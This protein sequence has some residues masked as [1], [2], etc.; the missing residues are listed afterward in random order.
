MVGYLTGIEVR[1]HWRSVL[2]LALLVALVVG[3]VLASVAGAR[4]SR[5]S[6]DRYLAQVNGPDIMAT[7]DAGAPEEI[8]AL[9]RLAELPMV[10]AAPVVDMPAASPEG[11][12]PLA[13]S[14]D[15]L[16]PGTYLKS[17]IIA[18]READPSAPFEVTLS[19]RTARILEVGVGDMIP[20][21][22]FGPEAAAAFGRDELEEPAPDGPTFELTVVGIVRD[23]GDIASRSTDLTLTFLTPAF[24]DR[25]PTT[26]IGSFA[27]GRFIVLKEGV[28]LSELSAAA[29]HLPI[30]LDVTFSAGVVRSQADP[31]MAAIATALY[32]FA[33]VAAV[34]GL[35]TIGHAVGRM[36]TAAADDD[37]TLAAIG[38]GRAGRWARVM[39]PGWA[40]MAVGV[41]LGMGLAVAASPLFPIGL[42]R[43]AEPDLGVHVDAWLLTLGAGAS[44][45]AGLALVAL[46]GRLSARAAAG[47]ARLVRPSQ[48]VGAATSA[49]APPAVVTGLT[50]ALR[51]SRR[52]RSAAGAAIAGTAMGVMGVLSAVVFA[53][54]TDRLVATPSLYGWGW[55]ANVAGADMTDLGPDASTAAVVDDPEL[56]VVAEIAMQI[57]ATIDGEP[58][59]LTSATDVKGH[60]EPVIVKGTEPL[61]RDE[62]A[63]AADTLDAIGA[64]VGDRVQLDLGDGPRP[65]LIT[66]VVALPV[67]ADGGSS[68]VGAYLA[69]A[70]AEALHISS[71]CE[72][73]SSCYRNVAIDLSDT[74]QLADVVARYEDPDQNVAV[75]L[76]SPPGEVERL[77]AVQQ[78]PWFLAGLLGLLAAVAVTYSAAL[79]VRRRR[80]D[81]A[82]LRVIEMS[83]AQLRG[84]V[85]VQVLV[86]TVA[87]GALGSLLGVLAGRQ[88]WR[89]VASSL[90]LPF[91]PAVPVAAALLVPCAAVMITQLAATFSRRAAGR[92]QPALA[93]R[94]E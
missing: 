34:A 31:T 84:L 94:T 21:I 4:R 57:E 54:S 2:L 33:G 80:R 28:E 13:V 70:A 10:A 12:L 78:L 68:T 36:Q 56:R 87:G 42:A 23:A 9:D 44:L 8:E 65:M 19:E 25:F 20:M 24:R 37:D 40:A 27:R 92:T 35:A 63:V 47:P 48:I 22:S 59:F 17:P 58:V 39:A 49:G 50:L 1:R 77:T 3:T 46:L 71:V 43:R 76:P 66:G 52:G 93:L 15:G 64:E 11:Y 83:A 61:Q 5:T 55:D 14:V 69:T 32:V 81:L 16:V 88:V 62:I 91:S 86:L 60:L 73:A 51:S 74:A 38:V 30:E 75:D 18:G 67:S 6:F 85:A 53:A 26:T 89:W 90:A 79:A 29:A 41:P 82:V 7:A 72:D 45:A